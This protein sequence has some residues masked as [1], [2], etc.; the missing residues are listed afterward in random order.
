MYWSCNILSYHT[1]SN[2]SSKRYSVE[3]LP[4]SIP[5][6][7]RCTLLHDLWYWITQIW[8]GHGWCSR[9]RLLWLWL[10]W[11]QGR[12]PGFGGWNG[13]HY[14]MFGCN[15]RMTWN[16]LWFWVLWLG[17]RHS[18]RDLGFARGLNRF[19][20]WI[21]LSVWQLR[22]WDLYWISTSFRRVASTKGTSWLSIVRSSLVIFYSLGSCLNHSGG[23]ATLC[24]LSWW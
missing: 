11:L 24:K 16:S 8:F 13:F 1:C 10:P 14:S 15:Q 7:S 2:C 18:F 21:R 4:I 3:K 9:H 23:Y 5:F 20:Y 12:D 19:H 22:G 6:G 17:H